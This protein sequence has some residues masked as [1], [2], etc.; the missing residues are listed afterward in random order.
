MPKALESMV[1]L[2]V[3]LKDGKALQNLLVGRQSTYSDFERLNSP[4]RFLD[5]L[6]EEIDIIKAGLNAIKDIEDP[7]KETPP[8]KVK[9]TGIV[10]SGSSATADAGSPPQVL[11]DH[12]AT[13]TTVVTGLSISISPSPV[14]TDLP[15][16]PPG[17]TPTDDS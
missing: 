3:K 1:D 17:R 12:G 8:S 11:E 16:A 14:E 13:S 15:S 7:A 5:E 9:V 4:K 2:Y 6:A 10:L